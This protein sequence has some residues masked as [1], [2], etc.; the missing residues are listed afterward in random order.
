M[1]ERMESQIERFAP[2]FRDCIL[3]RSELGPRALEARNA[4]NVDGDI[5]GG[6]NT[7]SQTLARPFPSLRPY[8]TPIPG[9][10]LCSASTPPGGGVHGMCG[11]HAARAALASGQ[12]RP[13]GER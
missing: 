5:T 12:K 10:Y 3:A 6:A 2:G 1:T 4:N 13:A 9:V 11:Y 7:L 8:A